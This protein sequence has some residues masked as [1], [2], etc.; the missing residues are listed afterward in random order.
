MA[1]QFVTVVISIP[2]GKTAGF[3]DRS[4]TVGLSSVDP[5]R[6]NLVAP[7]VTSLST[8]TQPVVVGETTIWD[9]FKFLPTKLPVESIKKVFP[10][11]TLA[12]VS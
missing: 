10:F 5:L 11:L 3:A 8:I 1:T 7:V 6:S 12:I 4:N 9:T 2:F